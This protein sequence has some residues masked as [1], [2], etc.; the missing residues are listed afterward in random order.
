[1]ADLS[2]TV[3]VIKETCRSRCIA[4][5]A[6]TIIAAAAFAGATRG[7]PAQGPPILTP[8]AARTGAHG[9]TTAGET[10]PSQLWVNLTCTM[11][12]GYTGD[13]LEARCSVTGSDGSTCFPADG[14]P[15]LYQTSF[16]YFYSDGCF[17][18]LVPVGQTVVRLGHGFEYAEITDTVDISADTAIVYG[19]ERIVDMAELCWFPGDC[20]LHIDHAGGAYTVTPA[21]A[22]VMG[23][24]EGLRVL[25]CLDNAYCFTG[26]PDPCSTEECI[27]YMTEEYR[28]ATFGHMGLLGATSLISPFSS[29]WSPMT[30]DVADSVHL[31]DGAL[32]ISVHPVSSDDF[33]DVE[34]WPGVGIARELPVDIISSRI[35][36]FEVMSYSNC[37][38]GGI[39][40]GMWYRFLNCGFKLPA[41]AGTDAC[42]NR[43]STYPLGAFKTYVY[44]PSGELSHPAW[45]EGMAAGRT[46]VTNGPLFTEFR[47]Y[48]YSS[49]YMA[50]DSI[51]AAGEL[52]ELYGSVAVTC[53][54]PLDRIELVV[55]GEVVE[56]FRLHHQ[57]SG[58]DTN[59]T[60]TLDESSWIAARVFGG[61]H[62]WLNIGSA[63]FA[64]TSPVYVS[65]NGERI[66]DT[67]DALHFAGWIADLEALFAWKSFG[68]LPVDSIRIRDKLAEARRYYEHLAS[69]ATHV[70]G[71]PPALPLALPFLEQNRPNPFSAATAVEFGITSA[72]DGRRGGV[73]AAGASAV[74]GELAVYDVTGR[75]I[76]RLF[77]GDIAPGQKRM[78][79][80]DGRDN[81]GRAV[82]SGFYFCRFRGGGLTTS[83]KML[84]LR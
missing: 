72:R 31:Q 29:S 24:A 81:S 5:A 12:C 26:S 17:T 1:M 64:H 59:F 53:A 79:Y 77:Y 42:M 21:E 60:L 46:F 50:G 45:L 41:C 33:D 69:V 30:G 82:S 48:D 22:G 43:I 58:V 73:F 18:V 8:A 47:I 2:G 65:L 37:N 40:L 52:L 75:M 34:S 66:V 55:N 71:Q 44:I 14:L 78:L 57:R 13:T 51:L 27:V 7:G 10:A 74:Q 62:Y 61:N 28:S 16:D 68:V 56:T 49:Q 23:L 35:D 80:W 67:D 54:R 4:V 19:F 15:F 25:N 84:L 3:N 36:G 39:E 11:L 83:R 32:V 20:H 6:C 70:A 38:F 63:L 9:F 76:R